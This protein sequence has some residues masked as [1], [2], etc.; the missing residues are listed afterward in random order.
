MKTF[1]M[2]DK[3][4]TRR[5]NQ[6]FVFTSREPVGN[7]P[8]LFIVADGMGGHNAGDYASRYAVEIIVDE[9]SKCQE[10]EPAAVLLSAVK[11]ANRELVAKAAQEAALLGMGTTAVLATLDKK[12][13]WVAN[14]GDS[15][16]YILNEEARQITRDHSLVEEMVRRGELGKKEARSHPDRHIITRALGAGADVEADIFEVDIRK[17]DQILMC[18][19][20]L[21][22]MVEDEEILAIVKEERE[23]SQKVER[24]VKE[25]NQN[26]GRDNITVIVIEPFSNEVKTCC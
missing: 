17:G 7:L 26:G 2:T 6:D 20:G 19:D 4:K 1:S 18:S 8:N 16:L 12:R 25:A 5:M 24:L 3:G 13:L 9:I 22:N 10:R 23:I 21:T 14:V 15:R 11:R